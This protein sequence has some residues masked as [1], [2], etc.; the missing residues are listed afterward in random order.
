M[1]VMSITR[2]IFSTGPSS[3]WLG[4]SGALAVG[5]AAEHSDDRCLDLDQQLVEAQAA[6]WAFGSAVKRWMVMNR[7]AAVTRVT[8]W[9]QPLQVRPS[10]WSRPR[11]C[12]S[13]R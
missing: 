8:W 6:P 12:L 5:A 7:W 10:K 3:T 9:C 2:T 1:A 13:S 11:P 4:G